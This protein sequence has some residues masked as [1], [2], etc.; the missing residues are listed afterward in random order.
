[1]IDDM[2]G[3]VVRNGVVAPQRFAGWL[4]KNRSVLQRFPEIATELRSPAAADMAYIARQQQLAARQKAVEDNMLTRAVNS[5]DR[6]G[7]TADGVIDRALTDPRKMEQLVGAVRRQEGALPALR[8]VVWDRAM[9]GD[10]AGITKFIVDN[11]KSL[12]HL[13]GR[14]H[15]RD[16]QNIVA[17]RAMLERVPHPTGAAYV[18]RPLEAVERVIGQG[19]P[20]LGNRIFALKS[21]RMQKEY[22]LIDMFLRSL[23]GRVQFAAD[24]ALRAALYDPKLARDLASSLRYNGRMTL[25]KA[26]RLQTRLVDLGIPLLD[27]EEHR[28]K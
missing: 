14:E 6:G 11:G 24:D 4:D 22:L 17:A 23:R 9:N 13:F 27:R 8:R 16:I 25:E 5:Y 18:P 20:Q 3:D 2:R 15:L 28:P 21:G 19:L 7:L 26:K 1:V 10:A 12:R